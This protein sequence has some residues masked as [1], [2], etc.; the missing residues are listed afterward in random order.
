M[1]WDVRRLEISFF[2]KEMTMATQVDQ[3]FSSVSPHLQR[4]PTQRQQSA[5][6]ALLLPGIASEGAPTGG[7]R[8]LNHRSAVQP[9]NEL[10]QTAGGPLQEV[11]Q[12]MAMVHF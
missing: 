3:W 2:S 1:F 9:L 11:H 10:G 12:N 6:L 8:I 5:F 4:T 7:G